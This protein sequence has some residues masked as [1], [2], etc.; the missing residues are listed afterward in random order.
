MG[1][2]IALGILI[3]LA[4]LPLGVRARYDCGGPLVRVILGPVK[5]TVFPR[6]KK[7]KKEKT[8]KTTGDQMEPD[9]AEKSLPQPPKPPAPEKEGTQQ[10]KGGSLLDFLPLV[11][12]ALDFLG[13]FRRKLRIDNL[14]LRWILAS[15]DPCDLAVNYGRAWAAL[16]NL[17]PQLER[18]FKIKK[19]DVE[20]ECDFTASEPTVI[21]RVDLTITL[22]RLLTLA[23][24]YGARALKEFLKLKKKRKGGAENESET[25]QHAGDNHSENP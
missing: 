20:V 22:G 25:S 14:Y 19:R 15:S 16:G 21:A 8:S 23:A 9:T 6:P 13:D 17:M 3:C 18:L 12:V 11:R 2:L 24:V 4:V 1:W 5:L 7:Q 10:K